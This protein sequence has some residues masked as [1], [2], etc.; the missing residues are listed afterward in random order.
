MKFLWQ[1]KAVTRHLYLCDGRGMSAFPTLGDIDNRETTI[2]LHA[3]REV[4]ENVS[5]R[6]DG[7][8][9]HIVTF[10]KCLLF[11]ESFLSGTVLRSPEFCFFFH[12]IQAFWLKRVASCGAPRS[13]YKIL[14][15]QC[16]LNETITET[17]TCQG[18][19]N[20]RLAKDGVCLDHDVVGF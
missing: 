8:R 18:V 17:V 14:L 15:G 5:V 12:S 3:I 11:Q 16:A 10:A 4:R 1:A 7:S 2:A 19:Q 6:Y 20:C 9:I 13:S